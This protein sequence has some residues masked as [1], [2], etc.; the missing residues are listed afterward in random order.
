MAIKLRESHHKRLGLD[1]LR[2]GSLGC[3]QTRPKRSAFSH[4][5][6]LTSNIP[7]AP[8]ESI[9]YAEVSGKKNSTLYID[10]RRTIYIS[11]DNLEHW[12]DENKG[13][14]GSWEMRMPNLRHLSY[15]WERSTRSFN[16]S[17]E[18]VMRHLWGISIALLH[19]AEGRF[20]SSPI[21]GPHTLVDV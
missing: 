9:Y 17:L 4:L 13:L 5:G 10:G 15:V 6:Y 2:C 16:R 20:L 1:I 3:G 11:L 7:D 12:V 8:D 18:S 19:H 14:I 21:H